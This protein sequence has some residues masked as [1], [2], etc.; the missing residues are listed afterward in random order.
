MSPRKTEDRNPLTLASP[1]LGLLFLEFLHFYHNFDQTTME[2]A[3]LPPNTKVD[4]SPFG[5]RSALGFSG[6]RQQSQAE[7]FQQLAAVAVK[8][9]LNST[10]NVTRNARKYMLLRVE[11]D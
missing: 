8:D 6:H 2:V 10:N 11:T 5:K 4:K 7:F 1:N 3:P 9:P